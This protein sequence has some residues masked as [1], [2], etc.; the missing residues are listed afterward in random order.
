VP[1]GLRIRCDDPDLAELSHA[2][3]IR[4]HP[5]TLMPF[6]SACNLVELVVQRGDIRGV[7]GPR[8]TGAVRAELSI[9]LA[10]GRGSI[11][12]ITC[13]RDEAQAITQAFARA[14]RELIRR[15]HPRQGAVVQSNQINF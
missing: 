12:V 14:Q 5:L 4:L 6:G 15:L 13:H 7:P 2:I 3:A 8:V 10:R 9:K 11:V 1:H